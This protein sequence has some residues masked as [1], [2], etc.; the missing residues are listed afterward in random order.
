MDDLHKEPLELPTS[1]ERLDQT[2]QVVGIRGWAILSALLALMFL[3][4]AW[5]VFGTIPIAVTGKCIAFTPESS[6]QVQSSQMG[7]VREIAVSL[8]TKVTQGT[9]LLF[10]ESGGSIDAPVDAMVTS[11]DVRHGEVFSVGQTLFWLEKP[12]GPEDLKIFVFVP[13]FSGQQIAPGMEALA[14]LDI[15]EAERYGRVEGVVSE[16][17]PYPVDVTDLYFQ[18]IPS[19]SLK[20]YLL[21]GSA[22][23]MMIVVNPVKDPASAS[24]LKWT[25]KT[26]PKTPI[27]QGTVGEAL[28]TLENVKPI[29]YLIPSFRRKGK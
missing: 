26:S 14:D 17:V 27:R 29:K 20:E 12:S 28:I 15:A 9:P 3:T 7:V 18:K 11:I 23:V 24:G 16:I 25:S 2:L 1:L 19:K 10:L 21:K 4:L 22:P 5:A 13:V 6:F 8:G